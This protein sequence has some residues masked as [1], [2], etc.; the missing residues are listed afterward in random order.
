MRPF[1]HRR[2]V[3]LRWLGFA[4][5]LALS[6]LFAT[7][8]RGQTAI[9]WNGKIGAADWHQGYDAEDESSTPTWVS[10]STGYG[11]PAPAYPDSNTVA[12]FVNRSSRNQ[13]GGNSTLASLIFL[14]SNASVRGLVFDR[15]IDLL[16]SS[17]R[18]SVG[19]DGIVLNSDWAYLALNTLELTA[20]QTF[21]VAAGNSGLTVEGVVTA[22]SPATLTVDAGSPVTF[23]YGG[24]TGGVTLV[25]NGNEALTVYGRFDPTGSVTVN[26]GLLDITLDSSYTPT[27][28]VAN[29]FSLA[30]GTTL[31]LTAYYDPVQLTG[32]ISGAGT[33][34]LRSDTVISGTNSHSGGTVIGNENVTGPVVTFNA[35]ANFGTGPVTLS[36]AELVWA[37]G[38]TADISDLFTSFT[39]DSVV[40]NT[41][42]N[43]VTF[44]TGLAGDA[45]LFKGGAGTL[46][47]TG[48]GT[49]TGNFRAY[50]GTLQIG[51]GGTS[52]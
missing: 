38:N 39:G 30:S 8:L 49:H 41:N 14:N 44:A 25:K 20:S 27:F 45:F 21:N 48:N 28:T 9:Y 23:N 32:T 35:A 17:A 6:C 10:T 29:S 51:N 15:G 3:T 26:G 34:K 7:R 16:G 42:G 24:L 50:E 4:L 36:N 52:G 5:C 46:T 43:D 2:C 19:S 13:L 18:L 40:F 11:I 31:Q 12:Y 22:G 33:L 47:L 37:G 1:P